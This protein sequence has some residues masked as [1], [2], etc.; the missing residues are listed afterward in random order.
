MG[1]TSILGLPG[2][3]LSLALCGQVFLAALL[4][5]LMGFADG[6]R[7]A[8]TG[9]TVQ[10]RLG[11]DLPARGPAPT[12]YP[13]MLRSGLSGR[14]AWPVPAGTGKNLV[15]RDMDGWLT[16]PGLQER[17]VDGLKKDASVSVRLFV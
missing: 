4:H 17:G 5:K 13:V 8:G 2:H 10:A 12:H 16:V 7:F 15:L 3:S 9:L 1:Q 6:G 11:T 14:V